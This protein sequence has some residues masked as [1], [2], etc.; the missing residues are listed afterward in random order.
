MISYKIDGK[1]PD[2]DEF[3]ISK[4]VFGEWQAG[5]HGSFFSHL[6]DAFFKA[7]SNNQKRIVHTWRD[8]ITEHIST[9][10]GDHLSDE[11]L[12]FDR[13]A[14]HAEGGI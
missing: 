4:R 10:H 5:Q 12:L 8:K 11:E 7:D 14:D 3:T 9:W 1:Y 13:E 2:L 6:A